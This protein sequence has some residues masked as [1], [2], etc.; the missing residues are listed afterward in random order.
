MQLQGDCGL[1]AACL[2][3]RHAGPAH[4][5]AFDLATG[6]IKGEWC[7]GFPNL[8]VLGKVSP[9]YP[10]TAP[11]ASPAMSTPLLSL[12]T[13]AAH[14]TRARAP[15]HPAHAAV[16]ATTLKPPPGLAQ[17]NGPKPLPTF[18]SRVDEAGNIEVMV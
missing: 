5:T 12:N 9:S 8:P 14:S 15:A 16:A 2:L 3:R 13:A 6:E 10:S 18:Q 11:A 1:R 17:V 4:K 7:P